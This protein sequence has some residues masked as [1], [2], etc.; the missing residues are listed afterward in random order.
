[1]TDVQ[2]DQILRLASADIPPCTP[3]ARFVADLEEQMKATPDHLLSHSQTKELLRLVDLYLPQWEK[4][5][6]KCQNPDCL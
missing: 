1:M 3:D 5:E 4:D 2:K 6:T